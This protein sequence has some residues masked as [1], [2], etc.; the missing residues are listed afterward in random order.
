M[1]L[2]AY[3]WE[4]SINAKHLAQP[5]H[6]CFTRTESLKD[7]LVHSCQ[8]KPTSPHCAPNKFDNNSHWHLYDI[9]A[10]TSQL[11][12]PFHGNTH[13]DVDNVIYHMGCSFNLE[14]FTLSLSCTSW[15]SILCPVHFHPMLQTPGKPNHMVWHTHTKREYT[16]P[17]VRF[18]A[19]GALNASNHVSTFHQSTVILLHKRTSWYL[20]WCKHSTL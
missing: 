17:C 18:S 10:T 16:K 12:S 2:V 4:W 6:H 3:H 13:F 9:H 5:S 11:K 20:I 15:S 1:E 8:G 7:I 19:Q 14:T